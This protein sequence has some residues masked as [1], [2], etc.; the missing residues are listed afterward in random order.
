MNLSL[1]DKVRFLSI[2]AR[3]AKPLGDSDLDFLERIMSQLN[4][5]PF[6][7]TA[8]S[9]I[10]FVFKKLEPHFKSVYDEH[11]EPRVVSH[12]AAT[13]GRYVTTIA[14]HFAT[15]LHSKPKEVG[16]LVNALRDHLGSNSR[17]VQAFAAYLTEAC[18]AVIGEVDR[19]FAEVQAW[20]SELDRIRATGVRVN[21]KHVTG[22]AATRH[23]IKERL[24]EQKVA[25]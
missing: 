10:L 9:E 4:L 6:L 13:V 23:A 25:A 19:N 1:I 22:T 12:A 7:K 16:Q 24:R 18:N 3:A 14:P 15:I 5:P 11:V 17:M 8:G 21:G 2:W 20:A